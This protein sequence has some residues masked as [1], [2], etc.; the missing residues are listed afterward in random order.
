MKIM[1]IR[2]TGAKNTQAKEILKYIPKNIDTYYEP[3]CGGCSIMLNLI[4]DNNY[5]IKNIICSDINS[6]LIKMWK[7]IKSYPDEVIKVYSLMHDNISS[8]DNV[9]DKKTYYNSFRYIFNQDRNPYLFFFLNRTC[10]NGLVR[11][12]KNG[13]FNASFHLTRNGASPKVLDKVIHHYSDLLNAHNV[14]FKCGSYENII[15]ETHNN[16]FI[17]FDPPYYRT[18]GIYNGVIDFNKLWNFMK[19]VNCEY[20]LSFDGDNDDIVPPELYD[21]HIK[22]KSGYSSFSRLFGHDVNKMVLDSFYVKKLDIKK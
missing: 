10:V 12:N 11:Y 16:D 19:S 3:F 22:I 9:K 5:D 15:K 4:S 13:D 18:K 17:Y 14:E 8:L 1:P 7:V 6:D 2:W 21:K 20:G